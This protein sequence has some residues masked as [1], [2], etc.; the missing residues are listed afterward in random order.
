MKIFVAG[1]QGQV[2]LSLVEIAARR[3]INLV[4]MG[5]PQLD[6]SDIDSIG[7]AFDRE[8]PDIVINAA[9]YTAV[10]RAEGEPDAA[11]AVNT[12][13]AAN[14]ASSCHNRGLPTLHLSTDYIFDGTKL[15]PYTEED[16]TAPLG[17]YGRTKL[18]GERGVIK[19]NQRHIILRTAWVYSPFGNNF[20]KTML[21]LAES[22]NELNVV[23]DQRGCPSYAPHIADALLD[24][25]GNFHDS[26]AGPDVWGIYN[27][28]GTGDV[29]WCGFAREIFSQ[30]EKS[31]GP[32][33]RVH[34]ISTAEYPTPA[35]RPANSRLDCSKLKQVFNVSLPDWCI[36]TAT[37]VG[38]L[39]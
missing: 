32:T 3:N 21:R 14:L 1:A 8:A 27:M 23:D 34:A 37:C 12:L 9:A 33:A 22:R 28:A 39:V 19:A 17:V 7:R 2:A 6:I 10:D 24:I 35:D 26:S 13:G 30:S 15:S 29:S 36:G 16:A 20:V 11:H 25:A 5:R 38:R 4:A 31:A 18:D